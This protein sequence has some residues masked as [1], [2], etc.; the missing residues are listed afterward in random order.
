VDKLK[1]LIK[2]RHI[3]GNLKIAMGGDDNQSQLALIPQDE[4]FICEA[5][6]QTL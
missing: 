5:S 1:A 2:K 6:S 3:E 4:L